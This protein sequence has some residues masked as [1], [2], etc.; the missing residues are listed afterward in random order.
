MKRFALMLVMFVVVCVFAA[1]D[2]VEYANVLNP[3]KF[4]EW[5]VASANQDE[6]ELLVVKEAEETTAKTEKAS[7]EESTEETVKKE[8]AASVR[9]TTVRKQPKVSG[10]E[11]KRETTSV[12]ETEEENIEETLPESPAAEA[13]TLSETTAPTTETAQTVKVTAAPAPITVHKIEASLSGSRTIY[14]G[15][16]LTASD[17]NVSVHMS[18]GS[19][20]TNPAGWSLKKTHVEKSNL[21]EVAYQGV[22]TV[23]SF[24]AEERVAPQP[25]V[26]YG[27]R[28]RMEI[29]DLGI[30]VKL[31]EA[32]P[33]N[34]VP[35]CN[36]ADAAEFMPYGN[37]VEIRD[38]DTQ[39]NFGNIK[40][41]VPGV[42]IMTI[43]QADGSTV[44]YR[45]AA[46][47]HG[48]FNGDWYTNAAGTM[49]FMLPY[50]LMMYCCDGWPGIWF[51]AWYRI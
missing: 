1:C 29:P 36:D 27:N 48:V 24:T 32:D 31:I 42:T 34:Y 33:A 41:A 35:V 18:D 46:S 22:T 51:T 3:E 16:E 13:E 45:C 47:E 8:T 5:L 44:S 11:V 20:L 12:A 25:V 43:R 37:K 19:V 30:S 9:K 21:I 6:E 14:V 28:G 7:V 17:V 15:D 2:H 10:K 4:Q 50:D 40:N 38:H 39:D 26:T 49:S 23:F